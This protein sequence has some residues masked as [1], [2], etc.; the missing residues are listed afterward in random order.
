[1]YEKYIFLA[2]Q[3]SSSTSVH[4]VHFMCVVYLSFLFGNIWYDSF[5]LSKVTQRKYVRESIK[6][7]FTT[8]KLLLDILFQTKHIVDFSS[9]L[10]RCSNRKEGKE[11]IFCLTK[12]QKKRECLKNKSKKIAA[13]F[14]YYPFQPYI[15]KTFDVGCLIE[16]DAWTRRERENQKD[17][18]FMAFIFSCIFYQFCCKRS[19]ERTERDRERERERL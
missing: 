6:S 2:S 17:P 5:S 4:E 18:S 12:R 19:Q 11:Q 15:V 14:Q 1:M 16:V 3:F 9:I 8:P 13:G 7:Y 10:R